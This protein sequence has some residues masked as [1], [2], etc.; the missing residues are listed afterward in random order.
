MV[1]LGLDGVIGAGGYPSSSVLSSWHSMAS[2]LTLKLLRA[3]RVSNATGLADDEAL[4]LAVGLNVLPKATH[5][6]SYSWRGRRAMNTPRLASLVGPL[7][8]IRLAT[9]DGGLNL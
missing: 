4:G 6:R 2:L 9:R 8:P 1:E 7:R 3:G 5:D